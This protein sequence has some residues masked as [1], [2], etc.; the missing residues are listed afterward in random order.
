M[1][2]R[3]SIS[4]FQRKLESMFKKSYR[5]SQVLSLYLIKEGKAL[6]NYVL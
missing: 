3:M 6:L 1:I 4:S 2:D 5:V